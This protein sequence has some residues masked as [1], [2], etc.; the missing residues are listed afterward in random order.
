[1]YTCI[2][3]YWYSL[4]SSKTMHIAVFGSLHRVVL[5]YI[6]PFRIRFTHQLRH[7]LVHP[8]MYGPFP[9]DTPDLPECSHGTSCLQAVQN[10]RIDPVN[11]LDS[12]VSASPKSGAHRRALTFGSENR[13]T[14][15]VGNLY[16]GGRMCKRKNVP[17]SGRKGIFCAWGRQGH[18]S[19]QSVPK[20]VKLGFFRLTGPMGGCTM[21]PFVES[22]QWEFLDASDNTEHRTSIQEQYGG[23]ELTQVMNSSY[24]PLKGE[25]HGKRH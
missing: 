10:T 19:E 24:R 14:A 23:Y 20:N 16:C 13:D 21:P 15:A 2:L 7:L 11:I 4:K 8:T 12:A 18:G 17:E 3:P 6:A 22:R 5:A 25:H 1:M 9:Y